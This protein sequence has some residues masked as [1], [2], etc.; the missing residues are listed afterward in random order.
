MP[1][2]I[3]GFGENRANFSY[4]G[5]VPTASTPPATAATA[6]ATGAPALGLGQATVD[7]IVS[8]DVNV[9]TNF[10]NANIVVR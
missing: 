6:L 9:Q 5:P 10:S 7:I 4:S 8:G 2:F 3:T 1:E